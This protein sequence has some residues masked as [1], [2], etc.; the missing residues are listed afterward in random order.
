MPVS[1]IVAGIWSNDYN[2]MQHPEMLHTKIDFLG[3]Q[4]P[5]CCNMMDVIL[6][7]RVAIQ[8]L[9]AAAN[10]FT[11]C[12]VKMLRSFYRGYIFVIM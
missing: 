12:C 4:H 6:R 7:T 10:M 5:T 11:I 2:I 8:A 1:N 3:Q 9:H